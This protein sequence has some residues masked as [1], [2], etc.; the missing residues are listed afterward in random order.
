MPIHL[1][2]VVLAAVAVSCLLTA[3]VSC[4]AVEEQM[5]TETLADFEFDSARDGIHCPSCNFGSGNARVSYVDTQSRLMVAPIDMASGRF[6]IGQAVVVDTN[7]AFVT[8]YGNGPSWMFSSRG[9]ELV[10]T[11]YLNGRPHRDG[12]AGVA[13]AHQ[14]GPTQWQAG[15]IPG[16][17]GRVAPKGTTE[18]RDPVPRISYGNVSQ[19]LAYW[20]M[21]EAT[22][23][24][25]P[26]PGDG[27]NHGVGL[28]WVPGSPEIIFS[29]T[30]AGQPDDQIYVYNTATGATEQIT[31]GPGYKRAQFMLYAPEF[32]GQAVMFTVV[33]DTRFDVY[34]RV[35]DASGVSH[36]TLFNTITMPPEMPEISGSPEAFVHNG[37]TWILLALRKTP[38]VTAPSNLALLSLD[39]AR[40]ELRML[41]DSAAPSRWRSDPEYFITASTVYIYYTRALPW[42]SPPVGEGIWRVDTGLGPL[43][44]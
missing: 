25:F 11:R 14:V 12:S 6:L 44:H 28:R 4:A 26:L 40:P 13:M 23:A 17:L 9:S 27:S 3:R 20:R 10:Y 30:P 33:D 36:W 19:P 39:P 18:A 38:G 41:T 34:K 22:A 31:T 15:F 5:A 32:G 24:E 29:I 21:A 42:K 7:A 1:R 8:D 16:G 2:E 37:R 43:Q 35:I